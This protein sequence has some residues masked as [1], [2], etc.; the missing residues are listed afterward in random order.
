[1]LAGKDRP[2]VFIKLF[3]VGKSPPMEKWRAPLKLGPNMWMGVP[4]RMSKQGKQYGIPIDI[5]EKLLSFKYEDEERKTDKCEITIENYDLV[6]FDNPIWK[7]GGLLEVTW[8]YPGQMTPPR[9]VVI[10]KVKGGRELTIEA[11]GQEELLNRVKQTKVWKGKTLGQIAQDVWQAHSGVLQEQASLDSAL[12]RQESADPAE[13]TAWYKRVAAWYYIGGKPQYSRKSYDYRGLFRDIQAG[14]VVDPMQGVNRDPETLPKEYRRQVVHEEPTE[15]FNAWYARLASQYTLDKNPD[16]KRHFYN[17][18]ALYRDVKSS[19]V[20]DPLTLPQNQRNQLP[21]AYRRGVPGMW[22][23]DSDNTLID[24]STGRPVTDEQ[25]EKASVTAEPPRSKNMTIEERAYQIQIN[26]AYQSAQTQAQ[27]LSKLAK[28]H[29]FRFYIDQDG[30]SFKAMDSVYKQKPAKTI[31]WFNGDGEWI[32]FDYEHDGVERPSKVTV[33]GIDPTTR[34]EYKAEGSN[35]ATERHGLGVRLDVAPKTGEEKMTDRTPAAMHSDRK[36]AEE[37]KERSGGFLDAMSKLGQEDVEPGAA[38]DP[39]A[40]KRE[41]D[42]KYKRRQGAA[43]ELT[44]T[45]VGDPKFL[46]KTILRVEGIGRRLSGN[47][48]VKKVEHSIDSGGYTCRF[49]AERD[50]DNGY[51]EKGEH[52]TKA[53]VQKANATGEV[54]KET[55]RE[56]MLKSVDPRRGEFVMTTRDPQ[57]RNQ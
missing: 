28:K 3:P 16:N 22:V 24:A 18:R 35:D 29:G 8:G 34:A 19:K 26:A 48:A 40:A 9:K 21:Q 6:E 2:L 15:G 20:K 52:N 30:F 7:K 12:D 32:D 36:K 46:A 43:H 14:H 5:S 17:Y 41:A 55:A 54:K 1:V 4:Y 44:G 42:G 11:L 51:G 49:E 56:P 13:F 25:I 57:G 31:T 27:F 33:K 38:S 45:L 47:W 39:A 50:A 37:G 23:R 10:Q 53:S